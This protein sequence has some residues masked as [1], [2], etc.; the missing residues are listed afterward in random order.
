MKDTEKCNKVK[1]GKL[2][3]ELLVQ[4]Q[5]N[6]QLTK[7]L[8][9]KDHLSSQLKASKTKKRTIKL[10]TNNFLFHKIKLIFNLYFQLYNG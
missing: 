7:D 5:A 3:D 9:E 6:T 8:E 4:K 10:C 2:E 1:L